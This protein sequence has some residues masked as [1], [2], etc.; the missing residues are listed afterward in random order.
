[1]K[2]LKYIGFEVSVWVDAIRLTVVMS[3]DAYVEKRKRKE[4][5]NYM[6]DTIK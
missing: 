3:W 1:M 2:V 6:I 4:D 5:V